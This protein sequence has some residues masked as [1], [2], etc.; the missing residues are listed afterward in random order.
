MSVDLDD[1]RENRLLKN[2]KGRKVSKSIEH[3]SNTSTS[4][5]SGSMSPDVEMKSECAEPVEES[6]FAPAKKTSPI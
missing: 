4:V 3:M 5:G 2:T 1:V 6:K